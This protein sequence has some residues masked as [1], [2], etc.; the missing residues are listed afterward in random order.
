MTKTEK[1]DIKREVKIICSA[2]LQ[3][4]KWVEAKKGKIVLEEQLKNENFPIFVECVIF[5][6][7]RDNKPPVLSTGWADQ[8]RVYY[9]KKA[10]DELKLPP[11][12][13]S[14]FYG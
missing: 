14:C 13:G 10:W 12:K 5:F 2:I 3:V 1:P 7:Y 4:L 6:A 11:F 8:P 9:F